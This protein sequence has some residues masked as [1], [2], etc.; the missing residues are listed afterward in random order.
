MWQLTVMML[1]FL[2]LGCMAIDLKTLIAASP[3]APM[4]DSSQTYSSVLHLHQCE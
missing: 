4:S 2:M 3:Q 1:A